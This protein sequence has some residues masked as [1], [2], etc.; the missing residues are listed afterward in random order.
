[1][2]NC[3][4]WIEA[5]CE[6]VSD[7]ETPKIFA[8]WSA[9]SAIAGALRKKCCFNLGRLKTYP[10]LYIVLV[11]PPGGRKSVSLN[12]AKDIL[13]EGIPGI[14]I[15]SESNTRE[16]LLQ[17]LELASTDTTLSDG[18]TFRYSALTVMSKEFE[19]FL[20]QK[21]DNSRMIVTL[22]DLFDCS[23][24]MWR[25]RTKHSGSSSI[26]N[27]YLNLA[28]CTTP[29]SLASSFPT[30]AIG[31]G[32]TSRMLFIYCDKREKIVPIP[33]WTEKE[34]KYKKMLTEDINIIGGLI[35]N[36]EFTYESKQKYSDWYRHQ[37]VAPK[38]CKD[39][40]FLGWYE[41][42]P[43]FVQKLAMICQAS[44]DNLFCI[45]WP[46]FER[47]IGILEEM[48]EHMALAFRG[49]GRSDLTA[50][51]DMVY[52]IIAGR[53]Q[54]SDKELQGLVW[55]DVD[56]QKMDQVIT[57][58]TRGGLIKILPRSPTGAPEIWYVSTKKKEEGDRN[59]GKG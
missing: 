38:R 8:K 11:A 6:Y 49:V 27:V 50:D 46:V 14:P 32:L 45:E 3:P 26:P 47:A 39:E 37:V 55:R 7:T 44:K 24:P 31:G 35:G 40:S 13:I 57:T 43:L 16:S 59:T 52:T 28:G 58:L 5:F 23:D 9:I 20:G 51:I 10:N 22:T 41:R 19:I 18:S 30:D 15:S 54:I 53:S 29:S 33:E 56:A 21:K 36:Y 42:K 4:D 17:D 25:H 48:E 1:M 2:R 34:E 12:Y